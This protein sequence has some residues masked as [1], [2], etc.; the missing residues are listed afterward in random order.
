[1]LRCAVCGDTCD[2]PNLIHDRAYC[3]PCLQAVT[4]VSPPPLPKPAVPPNWRRDARM[5]NSEPDTE[6]SGTD[7]RRVR[8]LLNISP[9]LCADRLGITVEQLQRFESGK[10]R[11]KTYILVKKKL[12]NLFGPSR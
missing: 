5:S 8:E 12:R 11:S 2:E 10:A 1:M 6:P 9:E 4:V 3:S 7:F